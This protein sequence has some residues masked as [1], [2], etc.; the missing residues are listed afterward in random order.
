MGE[1]ISNMLKSD[2]GINK[3]QL[4][5]ILAK[6]D[7]AAR[8]QGSYL[9]LIWAFIN[10]LFMLSVY[11][12]VFGFIFK[13]RWSIESNSKAEFALIL[14][15]GLI[16]FNGFAECINRAPTLMQANMN[17]VK[18]VVFPLEILPIVVFYSALFQ[19]FVSLIIW[20]LAYIVFFNTINWTIIF[21][22]IILIPYG[23]FVLGMSW[24]F[25]SLGVFI[26][27]LSQFVTILT[28]VL[29]FMSPIFYPALMLPEAYRFL[30][31]LNPLTPTVEQFREI[32]FFGNIPDFYQLAISFGVGGLTALIGYWWF[33]KTRKGFADVL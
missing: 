1:R 16:M 5:W 13:A 15:A 22:P 20:L 30:F 7:I 17:Y 14:F 29:L 32:L 11:T 8:Y 12:F 3:F 10:P 25:A 24:L 28:T 21:L 9:G 19:L 26:R 18:K 6:R 31:L 27:D 2:A 4:I 33:Q 23:L